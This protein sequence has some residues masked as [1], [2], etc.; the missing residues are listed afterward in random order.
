MFNCPKCSTK[1]EV[2]ISNNMQLDKCLTCGGL[3]FDKN[4]LFTLLTSSETINFIIDGI[5]DEES[6][7]H[8][9]EG[10][11]CPICD[12]ELNRINSETEP[13]LY[14]DVCPEC[15]GVWLDKGE[16]TSLAL[17]KNKNNLLQLLKG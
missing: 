9:K 17:E 10:G 13:E 8:D 7:K 1:L 6:K 12:V 5:R 2:I 11:K 3:W 16:L 4:E 14:I 15:S